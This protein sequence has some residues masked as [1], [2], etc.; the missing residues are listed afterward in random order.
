[1]A[2]EEEK[3]L[4]TASNSIMCIIILTALHTAMRQGEILNLKWEDINFKK[5]YLTALNTKNGHTRNIPL[6]T[7]LKKELNIFPKIGEYVFTNPKT[8]NKYKNIQKTFSETVKRAKIK[9][10][11]F[12]QLRHS[13]A[14]RMVENGADLAVVKELLGHCN[15]N[16]TQLYT[17]AVPKRI[18]EA[19][20]ILNTYS[21]QISRKC[22][23]RAKK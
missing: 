21:S 19:I 2:I 7:T 15:L 14:T 6:T 16:V 10:I 3:K 11:T 13:A 22:E 23:K 12:H 5:G 20:K 8:K 9:H 18:L 4:L 1:M 17:H